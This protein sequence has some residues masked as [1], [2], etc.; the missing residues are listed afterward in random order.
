MT[1]YVAAASPQVLLACAE[2]ADAGLV[3]DGHGRAQLFGHT[4]EELLAFAA[5]AVQLHGGR[6]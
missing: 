5:A 2:A 6:A 4:C 1:F 3:V